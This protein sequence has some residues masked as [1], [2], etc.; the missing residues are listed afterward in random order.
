MPPKWR[1]VL[2]QA[3]TDKETEYTEILTSARCQLVVVA[4]E[5]GGRWSYEAADFLWQL[6][7]AKSREGTCF[8]EPLRHTCLGKSGGH[9]STV[10]AVSFA[11]SLM[12]LC[13][14]EACCHTD[15]EAPSAAEVLTHDPK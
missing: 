6:A 9:R 11:A 4:I 12:E 10:C 5:T 8:H 7:K 2:I 14:C 15:G 3:R 13:E 1:A